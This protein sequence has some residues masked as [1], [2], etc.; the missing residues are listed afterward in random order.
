MTQLT[1]TGAPTHPTPQSDTISSASTPPAQKAVVPRKQT[2]SSELGGL[3]TTAGSSR[4]PAQGAIV[5]KSAAQIKAS[6]KRTLPPALAAADTP[7]LME[8][9][10]H[11]PD[12]LS[13][14]LDEAAPYLRSLSQNPQAPMTPSAKQF[15]GNLGAAICSNLFGFGV[16][17]MVAAAVPKQYQ[18][19][20]YGAALA[21][22]S[23]VNP[24]MSSAI[25]RKLGG[26]NPSILIGRKESA[27]AG[28]YTRIGGETLGLV[29]NLA[30]YGTINALES[31]ALTSSWSSLAK[32]ATSGIAMAG[33][34]QGLL[35]ALAKRTLSKQGVDDASKL[36]EMDHNRTLASGV[37]LKEIPKWSDRTNKSVKL[38]EE[39]AGA[40]SSVFGAAAAGAVRHFA[41]ESNPALRSFVTIMGGIGSYF[42]A[43]QL[44]KLAYTK[45]VDH[46]GTFANRHAI[47]ASDVAVQH[48]AQS[49]MHGY[50]SLLDNIGDDIARGKWGEDSKSTFDNA[51]AVFHGKAFRE[52]SAQPE[53]AEAMAAYLDDVRDTLLSGAE[54][55]EIGA[56]LKEMAGQLGDAAASIRNANQTSA[57]A[58]PEAFHYAMNDARSRLRDAQALILQSQFQLGGP[59]LIKG[60]EEVMTAGVKLAPAF[61]ALR[62]FDRMAA[63]NS[64]VDKVVQHDLGKATAQDVAALFAA[65]GRRALFVKDVVARFNGRVDAEP[66]D[67]ARLLTALHT[68]LDEDFHTTP[69]N[70]ASARMMILAN[71]MARPEQMGKMPSPQETRAVEDFF[72]QIENAGDGPIAP[73]KL[74]EFVTNFKNGGITAN[75]LQHELRRVAE[76]AT[77][78]P[79]GSSSTIPG[80]F[81]GA[82]EEIDLEAA[83]VP[84]KYRQAV[85][86][87]V[88][89]MGSDFAKALA[90]EDTAPDLGKDAMDPKH[91]EGQV[92]HMIQAMW[93][94]AEKMPRPHGEL[95]AGAMS[96]NIHT[97]DIPLYVTHDAHFHPTS[98]SGRVNSLTHLLD[99]MNSNGVAR[100]NLAGIPSQQRNPRPDRKYYANSEEGIYYRDHDKPLLDQY[101]LLSDEDKQRF[102]MSMT[103]FDVTDG[104]TIGDEMDSRMRTDPGAYKAVGEVTWKK[105]IV[106]SK[107]PKQPDLDSEATMQ[108]LEGAAQRG[109]PVILHCDRGTPDDKNKYA[110]QVMNNIRQAVKRLKW[111]NNDILAQKGI[112]DAPKVKPRYVWAHGAGISRF[113]AESPD[114]TRSLDALLSDEELKDV[115]SLDLSWDFIGHDIVENVHDSLKRRNLAPEL[116]NGMQNLLKAYKTFAEEG[117]RADKCDDMGDLNMAANHRVAAKNAER[118]YYLALQDFK[119][120]LSEALKDK[121]TR[122]AFYEMMDNHGDQGN[123]WLHLFNKHQDRLMF[124]TDALAVG[125]KAHG[126]AAYA[127]NVRVLN[128]LY[129]LFDELGEH[130]KKDGRTNETYSTISEKV[131][132]KNYE[133]VF[134][135]PDVT[136]RRNAWEQFLQTE[137]KADHSTNRVPDQRSHNVTDVRGP[138]GLRQRFDARVKGKA[139]S[140]VEVS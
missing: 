112:H 115:L 137:K 39:L 122:E 118:T 49:A 84:S 24:D 102:D 116:C 90:E 5:A 127:L 58:Q 31:L 95:M 30:T 79:A 38:Q 35:F 66:K 136:A 14:Y 100:T 41:P 56:T 87:F 138:D 2:A 27:V 91:G 63:A 129:A 105:E 94:D 114:H 109:L 70:Q 23:L 88:K 92:A 9:A 133:A 8:V 81:P 71:V 76:S 121:P 103:G 25:A 97:A 104:N 4:T 37:Y 75:A 80:A 128:P 62:Q 18:G 51:F 124:G 68:M 117:G 19:L 52:G 126:D 93:S 130:A 135:D 20:A 132:T 99:F 78:A 17:T 16:P 110:Q 96:L 101:R 123:N 47:A 60:S 36:P 55:K 134:D 74:S 13:Q 83:R 106:S 3:Q 140:G 77:E 107:N 6:G 43:M 33:V 72:R 29:G 32:S 46:P 69:P 15:F 50:E 98:Y 54:G 34:M 57:S 10:K 22:T 53:K 85:E 89:A 28:P 125:I 64:F 86:K 67:R 42:A 82:A 111:E 59:E 26:A 73:N 61:A 44:G 108:L 11:D 65:N 12:K 48:I 131:T 113:T 119:H 45:L 40:M 120:R 139:A 7:N 21:A 1:K